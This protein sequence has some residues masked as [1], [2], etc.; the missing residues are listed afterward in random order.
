MRQ[1][2]HDGRM[3]QEIPHTAMAGTRNG[4]QRR[5]DMRTLVFRQNKICNCVSVSIEVIHRRILPRK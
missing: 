3:G 1:E 4:W 5:R 2:R